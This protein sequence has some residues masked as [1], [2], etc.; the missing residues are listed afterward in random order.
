VKRQAA[1]IDA[2]HGS[3]GFRISSFPLWVA[4]LPDPAAVYWAFE[5]C[6]VCD[7]RRWPLV[8]SFLPELRCDDY[9]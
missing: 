7:F 1:G 6:E 3:Q 5:G 9:A 8:A 2:V 4:E